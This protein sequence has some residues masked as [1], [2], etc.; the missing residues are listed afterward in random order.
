MAGSERVPVFLIDVDDAA[1]AFLRSL[2]SRPVY[3]LYIAEKL[4]FY[5]ET[6]TTGELSCVVVSQGMQPV[7]G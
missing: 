2:N 6:V 3:G 4:L 7:L 1:N 5:I